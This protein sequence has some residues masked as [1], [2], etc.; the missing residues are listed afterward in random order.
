MKAERI[1][2]SGEMASIVERLKRRKANA[3]PDPDWLTVNE[4]IRV[5]AKALII[6]DEVA[7]FTLIGLIATERI[8]TRD[9]DL[10]GCKL[11]ELEQAEF[12]SGSDLAEWLPPPPN[13]RDVVIATLVR[14]GANPPRTGPWKDFCDQVRNQCRSGWLGKRPGHGFTDKQIQRAVKALRAV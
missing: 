1:V 5:L 6:P 2:A 4:A 12:V 3:K 11:A 14:G 9:L 7:Q 10:G 13:E 8:R